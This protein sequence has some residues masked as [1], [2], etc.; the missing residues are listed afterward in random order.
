MMKPDDVKPDE[1]IVKVSGESKDYIGVCCN[2]LHVASSDRPYDY[3]C[4]TRGTGKYCWEHRRV[5]DETLY[6]NISESD[7][8]K[9]N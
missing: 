2:Y 4:N 5:L 9:I 6:E 1:D 8:L 3:Y 7:Q